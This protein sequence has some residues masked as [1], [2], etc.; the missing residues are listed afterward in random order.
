MCGGR[1][2]SRSVGLSGMR[3]L[4]DDGRRRA[5]FHEQ[6][7]TSTCATGSRR[8]GDVPVL[9]SPILA[10]GSAR[11]DGAPAHRLRS[12]FADWRLRRIARTRFD[13]GGRSC[14]ER[15]AS[16]AQL[17][18]PAPDVRARHRRCALSMP[19]STANARGLAREVYQ[20]SV[21]SLLRRTEAARK[22]DC[23]ARASFI[24]D[25]RVVSRVPRYPRGVFLARSLS[26]A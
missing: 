18:R 20:A 3:R 9:R 13:V 25:V 2:R 23:R 1:R 15:S 24:Q 10:S 22:T 6:R 19:S 7:A 17:A 4:G 16:C 12:A 8:L 14:G 5:V 11:L 21:E 26:V